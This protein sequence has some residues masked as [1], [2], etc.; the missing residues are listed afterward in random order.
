MG[1]GPA[2]AGGTRRGWQ[3]APPQLRAHTQEGGH[4]ASCLREPAFSPGGGGSCKRKAD[5]PLLV[6]LLTPQAL[7][8]EP[9]KLPP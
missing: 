3:G 2:L 5:S 6:Y 4:E 8:T 9:R 7:Q 1:V